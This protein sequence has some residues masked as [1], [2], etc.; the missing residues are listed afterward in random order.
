M[1][2]VEIYAKDYTDSDGLIVR[3]GELLAHKV[4]ELLQTGQRVTI[5]LQGLTGISSSYFNIF[6][7]LVCEKFGLD[8]LNSLQMKFVSRLQQQIYDRS[9]EAVVNRRELNPR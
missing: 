5:Q 7:R 9:F 3:S 8:G 6:L 2:M 4:I 1:T